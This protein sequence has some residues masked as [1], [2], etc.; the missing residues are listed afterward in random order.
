MSLDEVPASR[1]QGQK[2]QGL[3]RPG[4]GWLAHARASEDPGTDTDA[5]KDQADAIENQKGTLLALRLAAFLALVAG[6]DIA[7]TRKP[8]NPSAASD[9]GG[10]PSEHRL[11]RNEPS[12]PWASS[13]PT[14]LLETILHAPTGICLELIVGAISAV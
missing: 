3:H 10:Q 12:K 2:V 5:L 1:Q 7:L 11:E 14:V 8:V 6:T 13:Q 9:T 4:V